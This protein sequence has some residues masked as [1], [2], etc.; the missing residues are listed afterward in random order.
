M[1]RRRHSVRRLSSKRRRS[2]WGAAQWTATNLSDVPAGTVFF[3]AQWVKVP[4][5][6][7]NNST[8][9]LDKEPEDWTLT[10]LLPSF[11]MSVNLGGLANYNFMFAVGVLVW[12]QTNDAPPAIVGP[13]AV[14]FP[15]ANGDADWIWSDYGHVSYTAPGALSQQAIPNS[16]D[17]LNQSRAMRKLSA[18][19]GLAVV[20][21]IDNSFGPT[22]VTNFSYS[23]YVRAHF[24]LP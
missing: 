22:N 11:G 5:G 8:T 12:E 7:V 15:T 3:D 16:S 6:A 23:F 2:E 4:A 19:Q 21:G 1:F 20:I 18:N 17:I 24:K 14:P 13:Q 10:R 9:G